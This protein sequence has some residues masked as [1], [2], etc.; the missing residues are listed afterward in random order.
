ML[1][2]TFIVAAALAVATAGA[3]A[4]AQTSQPD[5]DARIRAQQEFLRSVPTRG[6]TLVAPRAETEAAASPTEGSDAGE[7]TAA[8]VERVEPAATQTARAE[9]QPVN[10]GYLRMPPEAAID[11]Q[12]V[13]TKNSAVLRESEFGK[14]TA[15]CGVI[16][17]S[18]DDQFRIYGHTDTSGTDSYNLQLS[19]LRAQEV[20]RQMVSRCDIAAERLQA[21]GVG[22][23][24][25]LDGVSPLAPENRR[26]EFQIVG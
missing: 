6:L 10:D 22:E 1:R 9:P 3:P 5:Y 4:G 20:K 21:V 13:F 14:L 12:I 24:H 7:V 25:P 15:L 8:R 17:K 23:R 2:S 26:V 18:P 11:I 19:R 16:S